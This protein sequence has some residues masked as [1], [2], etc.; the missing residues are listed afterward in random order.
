MNARVFTTFWPKGELTLCMFETLMLPLYVQIILQNF[1][2]VS[3]QA[4]SSSW[5]V[6]LKNRLP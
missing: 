1:Q 6:G 5:A 3:I 4:E 2:E